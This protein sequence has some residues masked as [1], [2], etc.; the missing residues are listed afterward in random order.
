MRVNFE[1]H[2]QPV[3]TEQ[4]Q[5]FYKEESH[6]WPK[7]KFLDEY[8]KRKNSKREQCHPVSSENIPEENLNHS[9]TDNEKRV[10]II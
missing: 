2:R 4:N 9:I 3:T 5:N 1:E 8:E 7:N 10:Q 6:C